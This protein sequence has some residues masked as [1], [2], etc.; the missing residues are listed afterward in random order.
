M[1]GGERERE[2]KAGCCLIKHKDRFELGNGSD[3]WIGK[4]RVT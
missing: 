4:E 3:G 1:V 2:S